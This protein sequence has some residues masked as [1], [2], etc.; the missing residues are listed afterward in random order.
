M[1]KTTAPH[2]TTSFIDAY[3]S[4]RVENVGAEKALSI[5]ATNPAAHNDA[6]PAVCEFM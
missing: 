6:R 1:H 4:L 5:N 2:R 3:S